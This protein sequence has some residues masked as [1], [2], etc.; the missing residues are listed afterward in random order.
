[1]GLKKNAVRF[2]RGS[3]GGVVARWGLRRKKLGIFFLVKFLK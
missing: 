3:K 2:M 1:M